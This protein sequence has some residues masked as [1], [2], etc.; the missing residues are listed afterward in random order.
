MGAIITRAPSCSTTSSTL[1]DADAQARVTGGRH[2]LGNLLS[3]LGRDRDGLFA[4]NCE[5]SGYSC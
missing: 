3:G 4:W 1:L 2:Q 5:H